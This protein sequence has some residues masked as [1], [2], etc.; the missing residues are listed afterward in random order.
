VKVTESGIH[1]SWDVQRLG[2]AGYQ[3]F[4]IGERLMKSPNPAGALRSLR[5]PMVKICGITNRDD[6]LAAI[7]GGASALGFNFYAAS[8]RYIEPD[9]AA[10]L[11]AA[12][13]GPVW[14]VGVFVNETPERIAAIAGL[15][16][17]QLHGERSDHP[18]GLR[19]WKAVHVGA[20]FHVADLDSCPAEAVLLDSPGGG[21]SGRTFDWTQATGSKKPI[22]LAGGLDPTNIKQAIATVRPWGVD[23][24]SRIESSPGRKDHAKMAQFLKEALS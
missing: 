2:A 3:A 16:V 7:D 20:G 1:S 9:R 24:C 10:G 15:D 8:P 21:G 6:A 23:V 11:I 19:V 14:K 18:K 13:P 22:I 4:L 12:L 5:H 17:A